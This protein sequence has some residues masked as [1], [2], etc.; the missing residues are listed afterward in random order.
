MI[1]LNY[2][3]S[4]FPSDEIRLKNGV[5]ELRRSLEQNSDI[6]GVA[7]INESESG[8]MFIFDG[9]SYKVFVKAL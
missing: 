7:S 5:S 4:S 9:F 8:L 6:S 1:T 2:Q 3:N